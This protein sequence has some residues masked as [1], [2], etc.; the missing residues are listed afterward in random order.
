[1]KITFLGSGSAFVLG[2]ENYH[3]NILI[4][5]G[6]ENLLYDAGTT[7]GDAL[8]RAGLTPEKIKKILMN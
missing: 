5:D 4:E 7:I 1:M 2:E 8:A 3:S 6:D